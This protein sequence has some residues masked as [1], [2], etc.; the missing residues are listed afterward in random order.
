MQAKQED[1]KNIYDIETEASDLAALIQ[2]QQMKKEE[3]E[4]EMSLR[5]S[6]FAGEMAEARETWDKEK[7]AHDAQFKE[8]NEQGKKERDR[9]EE[10]YEYDLNREREQRRNALEDELRALQKEITGKKEIFER[11]T[12]SRE[13]EL[14]LKEI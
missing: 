13:A 2:A 9:E 5:K 3:F 14:K 11:D 7:A 6:E 10:A 4:K 12:A 1:L 8:K